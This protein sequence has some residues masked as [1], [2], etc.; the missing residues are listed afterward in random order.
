M[1]FL[2]E[3]PEFDRRV[4]ESLRQP[5]ESG[6]I[7]LSRAHARI[8]Y[9]ARFQLIAAMNPCPA[10]RACNDADCVCSADQQRRYRG[11]I[12]GPLLDRIDLR[13]YV[14]AI[15]GDALFAVSTAESQ[16]ADVRA[17]VDFARRAQ[18]ARAG[19]LNSTLTPREID[20]HCELDAAGRIWM[21]RAMDRLKLSAR[22]VHRV[23][24]VARTLADLVGDARVAAPHLTEALAFREVR[25]DY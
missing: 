2:D 16:T 3:L 7:E 10:G 6:M 9:P 4:L 24:K 1:L 20:V 14:P 13:A 12:S 19:K 22:G 8:R 21:S 18:H 11:R 25:P 17:R 23:L 15:D 5:L